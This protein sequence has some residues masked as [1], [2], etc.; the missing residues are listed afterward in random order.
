MVAE[1]SAA[2]TPAAK[3]MN[4]VPR[5]RRR[6]WVFR[7]LAVA[8]GLSVFLF[9]EGLCRLL[10]WGESTNF[11]DPYVGFTAV[12]PLFVKNESGCRYEIAK[13]RRN[14]FAHDS[15]FS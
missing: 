11:D 6:L 7:L 1:V 5:S 3:E 15:F 4:G 10:D 9:A 8:L 13:S 12:H 2:N 14:F